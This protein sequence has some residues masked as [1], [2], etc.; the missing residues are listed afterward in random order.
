MRTPI[1]PGRRT[2]SADISNTVIPVFAQPLLD[3]LTRLRICTPAQAHLLTPALAR[4]SLRNAYHRLN[5]LV[6][7]GWL[8]MDAV[9]PSRGAAT[10]HYYRP[11]HQALRALKLEHKKLTLL[12]RPVQH[13]LE[14]LLLRAEVYARARAAGWYVG[15]PV[16]L[17]EAKRPD[18]LNLFNAFLRSRSLERYKAAQANRASPAQLNDLKSALDQLPLFLPKELTFEFLYKADAKGAV[19]EVVLLLVDDVRRAVA[20]QVNAL[21][22]SAKLDCTVMIRDCDS[23]WNSD[24][25]S[26][27]FTGVRLVD[28]QRAVAERFRNEL[29][30]NSSILPEVWARST[31]PSQHEAKRASTTTTKENQ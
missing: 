5:T 30:V 14:Y 28:M 15:S 13:V 12:Q 31:R 29:A 3:R 9:V 16:Y 17:P 8:V 11:S 18:A 24:G 6:K 7:H 22:L 21:P 1:L 23:V 19:L 2:T 10:A 26:L 25:A 27:S 20:S 4:R